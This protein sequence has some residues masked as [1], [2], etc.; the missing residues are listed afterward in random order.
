MA[1]ATPS[2]LWRLA[3]P[4]DSLFEEPGFEAGA[5]GAVIKNGAGLG[6]LLV[7]PR[8]NP[9]D[10]WSITMKCVSPGELNTNYVNPGAEPR[11]QASYDGGVSYH[12]EVLAPDAAGVLSVVRG[13]FSLRLANGTAGAPVT[14]G[15]GDAALVLTPLRAGGSIR[16]ISGTALSHT[17]FEG[18]IVLTLS[19][20]TTAAQA[21]AYLSGFSAITSY[22]S[23]AAGG[24][25][26]DPVQPAAKTALPFV[27]FAVNDT[28]SFSTAPSPD[29]VTALDTASALADG[30]LACTYRLPLTAWADDLRQR[31][32][33]LA[34]WQLLK[35]RGLDMQQDYQVYRPKEAMAWLK[36]VSVGNLKPT[37]TETAPGVSFPLLVTPID[38]LSWEA[39]AFPI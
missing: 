6:S 9:R 29:I 26:S 39:G 13:G 10:A 11:F 8:S 30:Y 18:A 4:P 12:W 2:D 16:I 33:E 21:A 7:D 25:G 28:W 35:R 38:P 14:V 17:F 5:I 3:L 19:T 22:M 31:V 15:I 32:C 20:G 37:V 24:D 1:Y 23:I 34:R 36:A 27:S